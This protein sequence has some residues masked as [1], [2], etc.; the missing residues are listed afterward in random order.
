MNF[1][2]ANY[3]VSNTATGRGTMNLAFTF[4][5]TPDSLNFVFYIVNPGKLFVMVSDP[6]TTATPLLNGVVVQQRI[7]AEVSPTPR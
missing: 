1:T 7:P 4:G 2:A 5:G 6:V 3:T